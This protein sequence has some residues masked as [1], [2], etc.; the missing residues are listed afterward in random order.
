MTEDLLTIGEAAS[1]AGVSVQT[2]RHYAKLGLIRPT[3]VTEAGYRLY[4]QA[5]CARLELVRTLRGLGFN[6]GSIGQ[7]LS[8]DLSPEEAVQL[9]L[10]ALEVQQRTLKRQQT[11]LRAVLLGKPEAVLP[12]LKRMQ[13][14][15]GLNKLE[16]ETFLEG[17]LKKATGGQ[18]GNP[19]VWKAAVLDLPESMDEA[20][21]ESWLELAEI[22]TSNEFQQT[23]RRQMQPIKGLSK[24]AMEVWGQQINGLM[25]QARKAVATGQTPQSEPSQ[26]ALHQ[27][28]EATAWQIG[29]TPGPQFRRWVLAYFERTYNPQMDRYWQRV[30]QLKGWE[31]TPIHRQAMEWLLGALEA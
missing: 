6:L 17:Q 21:L 23:L 31:Y 9:Q 1:L 18:T 15:A 10:E 28:L 25:A 22:A 3:E 27:W 4:S 2:L 14:L 20:Q 12:R 19:E 30:A 24:A 11:V 13:A 29:R 7:L 8:G 5:D 16:R 26:V